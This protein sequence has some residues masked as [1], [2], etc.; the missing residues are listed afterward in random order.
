VERGCE[1]AEIALRPMVGTGAAEVAAVNSF[2][3]N[4]GK[5]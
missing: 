2:L 4:Q 1:R 5:F 3:V